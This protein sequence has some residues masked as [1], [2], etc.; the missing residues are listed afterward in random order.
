M[1]TL[2]NDTFHYLLDHPEKRSYDLLA[3]NV[4]YM[5]PR[6]DQA[7]YERARGQSFA[8]REAAYQ[9]W[10]DHGLR[11]GLEFAPGKDTVLKIVLKVKDEPE[12]LQRW[13]DYHAAIVGLHNLVIMDCGSQDPEHWAILNRHRGEMLVLPFPDAYDR[14]HSV[15]RHKYLYYW[16]SRSCRYLTVMDADEFLFGFDGTT[17]A[18]RHAVDILRASEEAVFAPAWISNA[19]PPA[20]TDGRIDWSQ[21]IRFA[22]DP[23]SLEAGLVAGKSV[24]RGADL[25]QIGYIGHN[26]HV[27]RVTTRM[28]PA[29]FGRIFQFHLSTL[30]PRISRRRF[31]THLRTRGAL[32]ADVVD[33]GAIAAHLRGVLAA[34]HPDPQVPTYIE[35]YLAADAAP[36]PA[37]G[38][39]FETRLIGS[40]DAE[41]SGGVPRDRRRLR[42][43]PRLA[44]DQAPRLRRTASRPA[45]TVDLAALFPDSPPLDQG[46]H[47]SWV[48]FGTARPR[49]LSWRSPSA[50]ASAGSSRPAPSRATPRSGPAATSR[51][52]RPS[53]PHR[54][55][56]G[57]PASGWP[58]TPISAACWA[59]PAP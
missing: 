14:L 22:L 57:R 13:I 28:T 46:A 5:T 32:P 18:P 54:R 25:M 4:S 24:I 37:P 10:I 9:D 59:I 50:A 45:G 48:S 31:A 36:P 35:K 12:L 51:R 30:G 55:S 52:W 58:A 41:D 33:E 23:A 38:P 16:L 2:P 39:T 1:A 53:R 8:T 7:T 49:T 6:F 56:T 27:G 34:G 20:E 29:S 21:P 44:R 42:L 17:I 26:L 19:A 47:A 40:G 11:L 3:R 15:G 43:R